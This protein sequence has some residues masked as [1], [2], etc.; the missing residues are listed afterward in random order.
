MIDS[1]NFICNATLNSQNGNI[2]GTETEFIF[3]PKWSSHEK[4]VS[5]STVKQIYDNNA[6]KKIRKMLMFL[7]SPYMILGGLGYIV[8]FGPVQE[9]LY[10]IFGGVGVWLLGAYLFTRAGLDVVLNDDTLL[11]FS[12]NKGQIATLR[13]VLV[14]R[15]R[16]WRKGQN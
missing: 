10:F 4:S 16:E 1:K 8:L 15:V 11:Q 14:G 9:M 6:K 2:R 12:G 7:A 13:E 5:Y 3:S